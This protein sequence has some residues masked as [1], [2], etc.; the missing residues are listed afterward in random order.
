MGIKTVFV[1]FYIGDNEKE[2]KYTLAS[3]RLAECIY[4]MSNIDVEVRA[5]R[6]NDIDDLCD[7]IEKNDVKV[8]GFSALSWTWKTIHQINDRVNKGDRCVIVGGPEVLNRKVDDWIGN[9]I[10]SYG[11]G[12][13][14]IYEVGKLMQQNIPLK[15]ICNM[16]EIGEL[17]KKDNV[18]WCDDKWKSHESLFNEEFLKNINVPDL[19]RLLYYETSR[20]CPYSCGYCGYKFR[21]T[22]NGFISEHLQEEIAYMGT[23]NVEKIFIIDPIIGGTREG[24]KQVLEWFCEYAPNVAITAYLRPE[25]LDLEYIE[26]LQRSNID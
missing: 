20:G 22:V 4:K 5:A 12:E 16:D 25:Y 18:F 1:S 8:I 13:K 15:Q 3:L 7:Y 17:K 9:V 19:G 23:H 10:F 21:S 24:G 2:T 11:E 6:L 26:L 14:F